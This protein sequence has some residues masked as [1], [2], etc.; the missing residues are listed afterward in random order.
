LGATRKIEF[1][2]TKKEQ[3]SNRLAI[4]QTNSEKQCKFL[5]TIAALFTIS[6]YA[7]QHTRRIWHHFSL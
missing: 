2:F 7:K 3:L 5:H 1:I 4:Q 6:A